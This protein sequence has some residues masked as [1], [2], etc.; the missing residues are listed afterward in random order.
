MRQCDRCRNRCESCESKR[1]QDS[2]SLKK[3][4]TNGFKDVE[5]AICICAAIAVIIIIIFS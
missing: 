3:V 4:I 1:R 5:R 2:E